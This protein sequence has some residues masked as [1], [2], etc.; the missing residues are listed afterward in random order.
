M[1]ENEVEKLRALVER[2]EIGM[3]TT[4]GDDGGLR[5]RPVQTTCFEGDTIWFFTSPVSGKVGE[6]E[7]D[8]HVCF[9]YAD[10]AKNEYV[11]ITGTARLVQDR[12]KKKELFSADVEPFAPGGV[13]DPD[14]A[15]VAVKVEKAEY[16]DSPSGKIATLV[17]SAKAFLTGED[18]DENEKVDLSNE[19]ARP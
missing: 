12:E 19:E 5:S 17:A 3:F 8:R 4:V 18:P 1:S 9:A 2:I 10:P 7:N 13:D 16:W 11:S 6:F 15:L 14:L